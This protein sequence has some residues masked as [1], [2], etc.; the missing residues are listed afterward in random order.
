MRAS[1][2]PPSLVERVRVLLRK[3][4]FKDVARHLPTLI[5]ILTQGLGGDIPGAIGSAIHA[6][7]IAGI[8]T[9]DRT[10]GA[11]D[12]KLLLLADQQAELAIRCEILEQENQ[13]LGSAVVLLADQAAA[14]NRDVQGLK[15]EV[16]Y[17][18]R[19]NVYLSWALIVVLLVA[20][21]ALAW[22]FKH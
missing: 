20:C 15:T 6:I 11:T 10:T 22:S 3:R 13:K 18:R 12:E 14:L 16:G 4:S 21:S 7:A 19:R 9:R 5:R 1:Q 17:L 8:Q 2:N